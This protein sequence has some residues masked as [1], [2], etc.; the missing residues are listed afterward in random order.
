MSYYYD[1]VMD[2]IPTSDISSTML[3]RGTKKKKYRLTS[4]I[5]LDIFLRH[6]KKKEIDCIKPFVF[7][8]MMGRGKTKTKKKQKESK[9]AIT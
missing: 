5:I 7:V 1:K 6:K 3:K 4:V 2:G 8:C 9:L